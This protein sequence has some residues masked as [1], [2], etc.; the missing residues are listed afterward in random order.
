MGDVRFNLELYFG[1]TYREFE[2][3]TDSPSEIMI[4]TTKNCI[5][6][7]PSELFFSDFEIILNRDE[8]GEWKVLAGEGN[9]LSDDSMLRLRTVSIEHG[10]KFSIH[11]QNGDAEICHCEFLRSFSSDQDDYSHYIDISNVS[12][13]EIGGNSACQ[14]LIRDEAIGS[15]SASFVKNGNNWK[16]IDHNSRYG[17]SVNGSRIEKEHSVCDYDFFAIA[18]HS[19]FL[20]GNRLYFR[21]NPMIQTMGLNTHEHVDSKTHMNYP[22]LNKSTR[23]YYQILDEEIEYIDPPEKSKDNK[24]NLFLTILP[25]LTMLFVIVVLRGVIGGGGSFVIFSACSMSAGI[26]ASI[27]SYV[28]G[29]KKLKEDEIKRVEAYTAYAQKKEQEII[30][31]RNEE[32]MLLEKNTPVIEETMQS[33]WNFDGRLFE[34]SVSDED[35]LSVR[36]GTGDVISRRQVKY[37]KKERLSIEDEMVTWPEIIAKKYERLEKAPVLLPL[38]KYNMVGIVGSENSIYEH[39]KVMLTDICV[40]HSYQDVKLGIMFPTKDLKKYEWIK[41]FRHFYNE[42]SGLRNI[43]YDSQSY[44]LFAENLY[45][46]LNNRENSSGPAGGDESKTQYVIFIT[47]PYEIMSHPLSRFFK[48]TEDYG[49]TFVFCNESEELLPD[50]QK[51][52]RLNDSGNEMMDSRNAGLVQHYQSFSIQDNQVRRIAQ[53]MAC[54]EVDEVSLESQLTKSITL[55]RLLG[56]FKAEDL[57]LTKRWEESQVYKTMAVPL[58]VDA[59]N[60]IVYLDLHEKAHGPHGLVAGTT[61]SGKSEILQTYIL[62]VATLFHP[63]EVSFMI[64]DFKGGGMVNQFKDLPHLAGSITDID[65]REIDRSLMSI[66]AEINKRKELFA[67]AGVNQISHYI[68]K[69][70]AKEVSVPLPHLILIVDEFAELK[71]EQPQF[72]KELISTA[73]VGRSLGIHLILATQK[74]SGVVDAQIWSNSRFRLCLKVASPEDSKEMLKTPLAAEIREPGRAYLQVGND[75]IFELFQ[76]AYSGGPSDSEISAGHRDYQIKQV[77]LNGVKEEIF[78]SKHEKKSGE[79]ITQLQNIVN[80]IHDYCENQNIAHLP[81]ICLP[82]LSQVI[83][84]DELEYSN[85]ASDIVVPIGIYDDPELQVQL[86]V[87]LAL[88][89][90]NVYIV[91]SS[92]MGKTILLQTIIYG[93]M[94]KYSSEQVNLYLVDCGSMV[95]KVFEKA[96]H[97]GG[98][99]LSNENEKC[100]NLF[101]LLFHIVEE[102]KKILSQSGV[103]NYSAYLEAGHTDLPMIVFAIDN[104]A[105]F[106]EFFPNE[107]E[108]IGSLSREAIGVGISI[109][110]TAAT[111]NALNYRVLANFGFKMTL[112]C[113]DTSEYGSIFGHCGITPRETPGRG[114]VMLDKRVLEW[115]AAIFGKSEK[116][117]ERSR[118]MMAFIDTLTGKKAKSIPVIPDQPEWQTYSALEEVKSAAASGD[119]LPF[120]YD[121]EAADIYSLN[122]RKFYTYIISGKGRT[123]KTNALKIIACSAAMAGCEVVIFD[124]TNELKSLAN[125]IK[126]KHINNRPDMA[127]FFAELLPQFVERNQVKKACMEEGFSEEKLYQKMK[128]FQKKIFIICDLV[129]FVKNAKKAE[130]G[131][132]DFSGFLQNILDKGTGHNVFWFASLNQDEAPEVAADKTYTIFV[133]NKVGA[134]FGGSVQEQRLLQFPNL[135]YASSTKKLKAG[136]AFLSAHEG[137]ETDS[138]V[139]PI[140]QTEREI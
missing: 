91:G 83:K 30:E 53:K 116:E 70:R 109:V 5:F 46:E 44:K 134:Y 108:L 95:L 72:M 31:K 15:D 18:G 123:G 94:K 78:S 16:I 27:I 35:F 140:Y 122:L 137:D 77:A 42:N 81:G 69:Y 114:L 23:I 8:N 131:V 26:I 38:R 97:V 73:R 71:A 135:N 47:E 125:E 63:Y 37:S 55:F 133:R 24:Q 58:G 11:Y 41:W 132:Q 57:D 3:G 113:N 49:V 82:S 60:E 98:V 12:S 85:Y 105:A 66:H 67:Q 89:K 39:I 139:V 28:T 13:I 10:S 52:I 32:M 119:Y 19:F 56:I 107:S 40:R 6:R 136:N 100:K 29:K 118:E 20:K 68:K 103:G 84:T 102:R 34:R 7:L 90:D 17:V 117:V 99:V 62:S 36:V 124:F 4:G 59:K 121:K 25:S 127:T 48:M 104:F 86:P 50:C 120:G 75:E 111:S 74:P 93:L 80:Y 138:I 45:K 128:P 130:D 2:V 61:G 33:V 112:N 64:I 54:V 106:K 92:Q 51:L 76:S 79:S 96:P 65:G 87:E 1:E 126:A 22:H 14:I 101:K 129:A 43:A 9:Y 21:N 110:I 115:Q 88:S